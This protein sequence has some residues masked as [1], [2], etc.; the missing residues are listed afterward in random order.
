MVPIYLE[1]SD[2]RARTITIAPP[3]ELENPGKI[4]LYGDYLLINEPTKGIHILDNT[5]PIILN[6]DIKTLRAFTR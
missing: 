4:Y 5:N 2:V 1:M 3:Q 6:K